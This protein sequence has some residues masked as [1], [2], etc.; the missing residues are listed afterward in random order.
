[1]PQLRVL[2]NGQSFCVVGSRDVWMFSASVWADVWGPEASTL[3]VSGGS[4]RRADETSD[5]LTWAMPH[6]LSRGD[7][8]DILFEPGVESN[9]KGTPFKPE[10]KST[11]DAGA[12]FSPWPPSDA[13][14]SE[15]EAR[16]TINSSLSWSL[17]LN[18]A[19]PVHVAPERSRQHIGMHILCDEERP[20]R[21]RVNLS[22]RSIREICAR[23]NGEELL[24]EYVPMGSHVQL[25]IGA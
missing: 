23:E 8:I 4:K 10:P 2:R 12:Q 11:P 19:P 18:G 3:D 9:P 14:L 22:K 13:E 25:A 24:L 20:E 15:W 6:E 5:F 17:V 21:L 16:P 7:A 1:M